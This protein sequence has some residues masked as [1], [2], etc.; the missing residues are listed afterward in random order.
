[1][2]EFQLRVVPLTIM[3]L[4]WS[5]T[6][7]PIKRRG[8]EAPVGQAGGRLKGKPLV[9]ARQ[10][11]YSALKANNYDPKTLSYKRQTPYALDEESG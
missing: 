4:P 9:Q 2:Q 6:S 10:A 7:A 3:T 11:I 5:Y 8:K 1:M